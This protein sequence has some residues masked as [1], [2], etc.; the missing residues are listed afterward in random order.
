[1]NNIFLSIFISVLIHFFIDRIFVKRSSEQ[2]LTSYIKENFLTKNLRTK[3]GLLFDSLLVMSALLP[4]SYL[5]LI[6][7]LQDENNLQVKMSTLFIGFPIISMM[8]RGEG[9]LSI[10]YDK[11]YQS[12]IMII[13]YDLLFVF[14][15]YTIEVFS[16][17]MISSIIFGIVM[18][19][20]FTNKASLIMQKDSAGLTEIGKRKLRQEAKVFE[21]I[22]FNSQIICFVGLLLI[23]NK[24]ITIENSIVKGSSILIFSLLIAILLNEVFR[25]IKKITVEPNEKGTIRLSSQYLIVGCI[26]SMLSIFL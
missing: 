22:Y 12:K 21:K 18:L 26:I 1:M 24:N 15:I 13:L 19:L 3:E 5:V 11:N 25:N 16:N 17:M 4:L 10:F 20:I 2:S 8:A 23:L 7:I 6:L 14:L 9:S